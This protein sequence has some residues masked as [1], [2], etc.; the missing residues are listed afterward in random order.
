[1]SEKST[2]FSI[3]LQHSQYDAWTVPLLLRQLQHIYHGIPASPGPPFSEYA[4]WLPLRQM[5]VQ[6]VFWKNQLADLPMTLIGEGPVEGNHPDGQLQQCLRLLPSQFTFAT[7]LYA[8]WAL[9]LS[10][11]ADT[12]R[13][14]FGGAV[15]G[16]T[17]DMDGIHD[18]VG[19]CIN[20]IPF[21]VEISKCSTYLEALQT[22]QEAMIVMTLRIHADDRY[23]TALY[24]LEPHGRD[25]VN[26]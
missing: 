4:S 9:V 22:V 1:M 25:R 2:H 20:M 16:R 10:K 17:I 26:L 15:S 23:R 5:Q 7:T 3:G 8:S 24:V 18:V 6:K 11:H 19:P 21:A 13:V 12:G 14:V